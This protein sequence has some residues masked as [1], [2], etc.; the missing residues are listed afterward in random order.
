MRKISV[1]NQK[2]GV[3]KTTTTINLAS[4]LAG[5]NQRVLIVDFD[6]Q[7]HLTRALG[8]PDATPP[9]TL[10]QALTGEWGGQLG[11]LVCRYQEHLHVMTTNPRM[12]LIEQQ[13]Y[14]VTGREHLL[15]QLLDAYN[16][17][18]DVCLIDC[19]PSLGALTDNALVAAPEVLIPVQA[20]DSSIDALRLL[21]DQIRTIEHRVLRNPITILGL[22][23]NG[24]DARRGTVP[25]STL[26]AFHSMQGIE[27]LA[28][29][30]DRKEMREAWRVHT[31]VVRHAPGS[32]AA[33][34]YRDLAMRLVYSE[35]KV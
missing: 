31:P 26:K 33:Q 32:E 20:E 15:A 1:V 27:V 30:G 8:L 35:V 11:E 6:P 10:A 5:Q 7:G 18:Y 14:G 4:A 23:V 29:I 24:Y 34:W 21:F 25:R 16:D 12:F 19:P 9:A 2:G 17:A 13:I 3:G 22:V 28:V